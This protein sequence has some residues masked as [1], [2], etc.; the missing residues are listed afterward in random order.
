MPLLFL[1][2]LGTW[3]L[4]RLVQVY[5]LLNS[6]VREGSRLAA[7]G[8]IIALTGSY[9]QIRSNTGNP[10]VYD[11]IKNTLRS[12]GINVSSFDSSKVAFT[13]LDNSGNPVATPSE[14]YQGTKG[15]R[16]RITATLPY[17]AFRWTTLNLLNVSEIQVTF[18]WASLIDD[19]FTVDENIPSW[20]GY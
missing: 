14:P 16:F 1:L 10:N 11:T 2:M 15:Q 19:P 20:L 6:A 7:Q 8:Q 5:Q 13:F 18:D 3:E 17:N 12:G 4:G 9:T